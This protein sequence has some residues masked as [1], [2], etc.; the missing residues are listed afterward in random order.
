MVK[1]C[2][3]IYTTASALSFDYLCTRSGTMRMRAW[4]P[5]SVRAAQRFRRAWAPGLGLGH[6]VAA[7]G[8]F[9][10]SPIYRRKCYKK[11]YGAALRIFADVVRMR[12]APQCVRARF[13]TRPAV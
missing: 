8:I 5:G 12:S 2:L 11:L 1:I 6:G 13:K 9:I 10:D 4:A 7:I 3:N